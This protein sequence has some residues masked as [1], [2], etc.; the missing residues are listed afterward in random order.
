MSLSRALK[1]VCYFFRHV[2]DD[3]PSKS[4]ITQYQSTLRPFL[5]WDYSPLK[6]NTTWRLKQSCE[7]FN[8]D[9]S[10]YPATRE[11]NTRNTRKNLKASLWVKSQKRVWTSISQLI[12]NVTS[13]FRAWKQCRSKVRFIGGPNLERRRCELLEG[14]GG[15][16]P[17]K[18]LK[19]SFAEIAF[20]P[21]REHWFPI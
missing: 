7:F 8:A 17:R 18:I 9:I 6:H 2:H 21:F 14:Y 10:R 12:V 5:I 20:S 16:L 11:V 1:Y 19:Y 13:V 3:K 15:V 4:Y